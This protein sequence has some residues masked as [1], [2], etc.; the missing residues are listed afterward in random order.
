MFTHVPAAWEPKHCDDAPGTVTDG[1]RARARLLKS[2]PT[3]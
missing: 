1:P 2:T 3:H